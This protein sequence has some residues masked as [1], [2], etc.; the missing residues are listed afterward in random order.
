MTV[1]YSFSSNNV[2]HGFRPNH[3]P[4]R[5]RNRYS[6]DA[7]IGSRAINS[8]TRLYPREIVPQS[9]YA[10]T[11][12]LDSYNT[13]ESNQIPS[14]SVSKTSKFKTNERQKKSR[15]VCTT[16]SEENG[17]SDTSVNAEENSREA[18]RDRTGGNL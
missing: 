3:Y 18:S 13:M 6:T 9:S 5:S 12:N 17:T 16:V 8:S 4:A 10:F 14:K 1:V 15:S 2:L 11:K 7:R